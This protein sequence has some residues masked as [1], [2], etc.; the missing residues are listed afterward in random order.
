MSA[1]PVV[2]A[3]ALTVPSAVDAWRR[4]PFALP[5]RLVL[6][7]AAPLARAMPW[8]ALQG[9]QRGHVLLHT[10][11]KFSAGQPSYGHLVALEMR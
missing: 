2:V 11:A 9:Q 3:A 10:L 1:V 4:T 8:V 7:H 5:Q 6:L